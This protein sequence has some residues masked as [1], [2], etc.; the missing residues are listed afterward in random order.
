[1]DFDMDWEDSG[2]DMEDGDISCD[3]GDV[4]EEGELDFSEIPCLDTD[5]DP[6]GLE[7]ED[8]G[9][10]LIIEEEYQESDLD[11][12]LDGL[13]ENDTDLEELDGSQENEELEEM[14]AEWEGDSDE[15]DQKVYIKTYPR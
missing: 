9:E 3:T 4:A 12:M 14:L 8:M 2:Q 15:D 5:I 7:L 10:D 1:M 13:R 6:H 11:L